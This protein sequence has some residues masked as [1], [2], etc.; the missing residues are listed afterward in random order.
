[1]TTNKFCPIWTTVR[2]TKHLQPSEEKEKENY[3]K[4]KF[5][6]KKKNI[7][8]RGGEGAWENKSKRTCHFPGGCYHQV[9]PPLVVF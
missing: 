6:G 9:P 3:K 7:K 2:I 5:G 8:E 1:M 4:G